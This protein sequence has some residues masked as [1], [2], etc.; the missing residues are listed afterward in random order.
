MAL[1]KNDG[2]I[3]DEWRALAEDEDI[4]LDGKVMVSLA[5]WRAG[6]ER[7]RAANFPIGLRLEAGAPV[8]DIAPDLARFTLISIDFPKFSDGRGFSMARLIR[9]TEG[10][11]G[12]L[13][14]VGDV[15]FDQLQHMA[16]C[17][18]DAFEIKDAATIR[19]LEAGRRPGLG[20]FY[21]PAA[22][23]DETAEPSRPWARR[24]AR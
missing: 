16:R 24:A 14:A 23:S 9:R 3:A 2:F 7:W 17:G 12:E 22:S 11:A 5:Q 15:L 13:R 20:L 19:L 4:P 1:F 8:Q 21:Q 18:F 6:R 10:F